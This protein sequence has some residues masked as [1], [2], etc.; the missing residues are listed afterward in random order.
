[1]GRRAR[2]GEP[3]T[4]LDR[5]RRR[6]R[7]L[8]RVLL[9]GLGVCALVAAAWVVLNRV[10]NEGK[11][12]QPLLAG[13]QTFIQTG[14][15]GHLAAPCADQARWRTRFGEPEDALEWLCNWYLETDE[16]R[17]LMRQDPYVAW[18][19]DGLEG[20]DF[21]RLSLALGAFQGAGAGE[22]GGAH[23]QEMARSFLILASPGRSAAE[24]ADDIMDLLMPF[25]GAR[26][27]DI[28]A[29][30]GYYS[31]RIGRAVGPTGI[32]YALELEPFLRE[33]LAAYV[34]ERGISNVR[35][36][37]SAPSD[38]GLPA[39]SV[40][41]VF[42]FAAIRE[43]YN[44]GEATEEVDPAVRR[45][46]FSS[47]LEALAP[48]GKLVV[49]DKMQRFPWRGIGLKTEPSPQRV[50]DDLEAQGFTLENL[51][52]F[53]YVTYCARFGKR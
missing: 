12:L 37:V 43:F 13:F 6:L 16:Y 1:M 38:C 29:G 48:G 34:A 50:I 9:L 31:L 40:D 33:S 36:T 24:R 17:Q 14:D 21:E 28:G 5:R 7:W 27:A 4:P 45:R 44:R 26:V 53:S 2:T 19:I 47:I 11:D 20:E 42:L 35:P 22:P 10:E 18:Y 23:V 8:R 32:V 52:R 25:P 49:C 3:G 39:A 30:F 51:R 15:R 41:R 46:M